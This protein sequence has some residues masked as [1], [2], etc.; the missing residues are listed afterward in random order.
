MLYTFADEESAGYRGS[1]ISSFVC[2]S[3]TF[4]VRAGPPAFTA[5]LFSQLEGHGGVG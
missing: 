3:S 5:C 1:V 4:L 2:S